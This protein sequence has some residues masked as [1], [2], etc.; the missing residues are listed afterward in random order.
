MEENQI[1]NHLVQQSALSH[2]VGLIKPEKLSI[3][4]EC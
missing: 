4:N 2:Y 3:I 1:L